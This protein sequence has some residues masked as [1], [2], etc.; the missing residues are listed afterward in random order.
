M[1][2]RPPRSTLFPYTTLFRSL[3][4]FG[5]SLLMLWEAWDKE[6]RP[7]PPPAVPTAPQAVPAPA[8]PVP[9]PEAKATAGNVPAAAQSAPNGEAL[10]GTPGLLVAGIDPA[11]GPVKRR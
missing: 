2:R 1:I 5:F 9:S 3:F 7:K 6:H 4:I 8:K 10:R 11:G